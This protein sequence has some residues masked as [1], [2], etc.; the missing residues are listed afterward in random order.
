MTRREAWDWASEQTYTPRGVVRSRP[1]RRLVDHVHT[2]PDGTVVRV[3]AQFVEMT[4]CTL[5]R[6]DVGGELIDPTSRAGGDFRNIPPD[7][8]IID[9]RHKVAG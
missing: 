2:C 9:A 3:S 8:S 1:G 5:Y 7:W 4:N 6:W